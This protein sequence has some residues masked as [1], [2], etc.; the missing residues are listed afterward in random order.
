MIMWGS[1]R[2]LALRLEFQATLQRGNN[3]YIMSVSIRCGSFYYRKGFQY[4]YPFILMSSQ[5]ENL[6]HVIPVCL[7]SEKSKQNPI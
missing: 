6:L 3:K 2:Q 7:L 1:N 4:Y 5:A